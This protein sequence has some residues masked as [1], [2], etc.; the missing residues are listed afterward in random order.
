M[1]DVGLGIVKAIVK[2]RPVKL[3]VLEREL[4]RS[5][6]DPLGQ[7][8]YVYFFI[9]AEDQSE[10][11]MGTYQVMVTRG[12]WQ[13]NFAGDLVQMRH[14]IIKFGLRKIRENPDTLEFTF[15]TEAAEEQKRLTLLTG[16]ELKKKI[17]GFMLTFYDHLPNGWIGVP[18]L[19][20][21]IDGDGDEI[22]DWVGRLEHDGFISKSS[23]T[24]VYWPNRGHAQVCSYMINHEKVQEIRAEL[25]ID[26]GT[27]GKGGIVD[28]AHHR[29]FKL[30]ET[31]AEKEGDFVF[32]LMPFNESEFP[33][34]IMDEV[35]EPAVKD[36]LGINCIR[37]DDDKKGNYLENR[38]FS[39]IV[40]AGIIIVEIS[41][42]NRNV[43]FEMGL[44]FALGKETIVV[45][46]KE[47]RREK[48]RSFDY[49]HFGTIFY[50]DY[51]NLR[52]QLSEALVLHKK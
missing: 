26:G 11:S 21:A 40:K 1:G 45:C 43:I 52:T 37:N 23:D 6:I 12:A 39:H 36:T 14:G 31:Q 29:Y 24:S 46:R 3:S 7:L 35:F 15:D 30:I 20:D 41:T 19:I 48:K 10:G 32:V 49:E 2:D 27:T 38:I 42:E 51:E 13:F 17:L 25:G 5:S 50:S 9:K 34:D 4:P 47:H 8:P 18:D 44:A 33:Q 28:P 16:E 22:R